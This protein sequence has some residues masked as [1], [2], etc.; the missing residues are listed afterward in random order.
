[1]EHCHLLQ[2]WQ[3]PFPQSCWLKATY[4]RPTPPLCSFFFLLWGPHRLGQQW[5]TGASQWVAELADSLPSHWGCWILLLWVT[6][7]SDSSLLSAQR[8]LPPFQS[9]SGI[10]PLGCPFTAQ[11]PGG[12]TFSFLL[13][14]TYTLLCFCS[15]VTRI[16]DMYHHAQIFMWVLG[17]WAQVSMLGWQVLCQL[18]HLPSPHFWVFIV[19]FSF[20]G[21]KVH[22]LETCSSEWQCWSGGSFKRWGL[23]WGN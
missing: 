1:M 16:I 17:I 11:F 13:D 9:H 2:C 23:A 4:N 21:P 19:T 10:Q 12:S 14:V 22:V 3:C 6:L 18:R 15:P 8:P 20:P 5:K 7:G